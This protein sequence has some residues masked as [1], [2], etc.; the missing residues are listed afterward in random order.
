MHLSFFLLLT[1]TSNP[2]SRS[3]GFILQYIPNLS[4][5]SVSTIS[6]LISLLDSCR[7]CQIVTCFYSTHPT[8][9]HCHYLLIRWLARW[10]SK[11]ENLI[12]FSY[13]KPS[14]GFLLQPAGIKFK[15]GRACSSQDPTWSSPH[16]RLGP[17]SPP[18]PLIPS[19]R[20]PAAPQIGG[21]HSDQK[22]FPLTSP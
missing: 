16:P 2:S 3:V 18:F 22:A 17:I 21:I 19:T 15:H 20:C 8:P 5:L 9:C 10:N 11:N 13:Q 6:I 7:S 4:L 12:P 1:L 14:S